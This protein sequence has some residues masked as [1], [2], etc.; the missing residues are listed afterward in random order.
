MRDNESKKERAC[1]TE[2][3]RD[4]EIGYERERDRG[5]REGWE[6]KGKRNSGYG[7]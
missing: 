5:R 3:E 1:V 2:R 6:T 7:R 4:Q